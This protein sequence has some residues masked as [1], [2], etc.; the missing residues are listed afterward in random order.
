[1]RGISS[2]QGLLQVGLYL[3]PT[4][5]EAGQQI[6][7]ITLPAQPGTLTAVFEDVPPGTY[8][9]AIFHDANG[10]HALDKNFFG[11]PNEDY[12]FSHNARGTFGPPDFA[13]AS[14]QLDSDTALV[15]DLN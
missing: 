10:N 9:V 3:E 8:A 2:A 7:G 13:E 6:L 4:F 15:I 12:A 11:V 5:P 1:V 14:F